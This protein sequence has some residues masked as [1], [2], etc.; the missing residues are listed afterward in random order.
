MKG[1]HA[2]MIK[3]AKNIIDYWYLTEFF[4]Q[5]E[6]PRDSR[7]NQKAIISLLQNQNREKEK[8]VHSFSL[9]H[10]FPP[11]ME[12]TDILSHDMKMYKHH[13]ITSNVLHL[14][15]GKMKR[16]I[17]TT[18]L[19]E[20][21]ELKDERVEQDYSEICLLG[22]Q[23][24]ADGM[25]IPE[26][27]NI[28]PFIWGVYRCYQSKQLNDSVLSAKE[29]EK[30]IAD[31]EECINKDKPL[32]IVD[33][34]EIFFKTYDKMIEP[35]QSIE[36][37]RIASGCIIYH[38]YD[39]QKTFDSTDDKQNDY[40]NLRKGFYAKDLKLINNALSEAS[41]SFL[42]YIVGL[43]R[44]QI[45]DTIAPKR[46]DIRVDKFELEYWLRATFAPLGKWPSKY[47]PGLM[48]QV[49]INIYG[50]D[51][52]QDDTIFSVN[53]P[54]GT[55]KTTLLKEI[56]ASNVV[57]RAIYMCEHYL[58]ADDAFI[59]NIFTGGDNN[60]SYDKYTKY[61]YSFRDKNFTD[62]G[63]LVSSCNN[64]AVE[65]ITKELPDGENL[66]DSISLDLENEDMQEGFK[67]IRELFD[68]NLSKD[69]E[70]Y[71]L[72]NDENKRESTS[73]KDVYFTYLAQQLLNNEKAWGLIS[74]PLGKNSNIK[75]YCYN[76]LTPLRNSF[77]SNEKIKIRDANYQKAKE[78]F[79]KQLDTVKRLRNEM[80]KYSEMSLR[81]TEFEENKKNDIKELE[82]KKND[83][84]NKYYLEK[85]L[86]GKLREKE[87]ESLHKVHLDENN[88]S[89]Y[90]NI[91]AV[92]KYK[93]L[94]LEKK[95]ED[96]CNNLIKKEDNLNIFEKIFFK[97]LKSEKT[98]Q[99]R[100]M[101]F[102]RDELIL[103]I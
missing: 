53:G 19:Y 36:C 17:F 103:N 98:R 46:V 28:S 18:K 2:T 94:E 27:F 37:E 48:Q 83:L 63:M 13:P 93:E 31:I 84:N 70:T 33:I 8:K 91:E 43:S 12:I 45:G 99:I 69:E 66:L 50:T 23:L 7:E 39:T 64:A 38:R 85:Q 56:V 75:S 9:F 73:L 4:T 47:A 35:L 49:A 76:V 82:Q 14:C 97:Y 89:H 54:P 22:L 5:E 102:K 10:D 52:Q 60:G 55:G 80:I 30:T 41:N 68:A 90:K 101:R 15:I 92:F 24:D 96:L 62:Y 42:K 87:K 1:F 86:L 57:N 95:F 71:I 20:V 16:E 11:E 26:S 65:N 58:H 32:K 34:E 51:N 67:T 88:L 59:E 77:Y 100:E 44:E 61:Y 6:F 74:A 25:Y 3:D 81:A 72:F 21:L 40:S 78:V 79:L 29:Y